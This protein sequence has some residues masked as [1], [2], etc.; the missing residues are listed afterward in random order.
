M[1]LWID[2]TPLLL[3]SAGVKNYMFHWIRALQ[4][5]APEDRIR[6]FPL[7]GEFG[8]LDHEHSLA[9][10]AST[11]RGLTLL[12]AVNASPLPLLDWLG[13]RCD[14]FHVS[15]QLQRPPRKRRVTSTVYDMTCW[16]V[17]ELH[18]P[19]NVECTRRFGEQ[20]MTRAAGLI[21]ISDSTREDAIRILKLDPG[22][23]RTIHPGI[24]ESFFAAVPRPA[25]RPYF[26]FVGTIEPRKNV[27]VL[28]D[29]Y[30]ALPASV[31]DEYELVV[32]GPE[33]WQDSGTLARLRA[34]SP[35]VRY[36]GYVPE[37]DLPG[38]TA[39]ATAF[40]YPSLYEGFGFPV[41]QAMAA[42]V[43]PI[44]SNLSS[45]PEVVGDAGLLVDPRSAAELCSAMARLALSPSLRAELSA[46]ARARAQRFT[47]DRCARES[48]EFFRSLAG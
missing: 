18:T 26:L 29:A 34:G 13:P 47:W 39:G 48:V 3:R 32:A 31:R 36:L 4:R 33:G 35:G 46:K 1:R 5:A 30:A 42:G 38:L 45:L 12:H 41:A 21:A 20:V 40:V 17:P 27:A 22:R 37:R 43:P 24:D 2:A 6:L 19:R 8:E 9:S 23:I 11:L 16:L 7:F 15:H 28:L 44:T 25:P 10:R 14:I